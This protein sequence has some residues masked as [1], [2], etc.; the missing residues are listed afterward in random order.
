MTGSPRPARGTGHRSRAAGRRAWFVI[1]IVLACALGV[2]AAAHIIV[3]DRSDDIWVE[4]AK[5]ALYLVAL[6]TTGGVVAA[7]LRDRDAARDAESRRRTLLLGYLD[8]IQATYGQVKAARRMLRTLGF[9]APVGRALT[10]EQATGFRTQM[11]LLNEVE[12]TF[13]ADGRRAVRMAGELGPA[14]ADIQRELAL[15]T[16]CLRAILFE[17][18]RD[19]TVIGPGESGAALAE[20]PL[21]RAFVQYDEASKRT[22]EAGVSEPIGRIEAIVLG[23]LGL[24]ADPG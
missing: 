13:E 3:P 11:A 20:W 7:V 4:A 9:D 18:E 6:A 23:A 17:W 21:F 15:V 2:F 16:A 24:S 5:S 12:L 22:F 19:P 1:G 8:G 14:A 10:A